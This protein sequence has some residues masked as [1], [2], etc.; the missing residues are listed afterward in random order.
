[1]TNLSRN[2]TLAAALVGA[3]GVTPAVHAATDQTSA[4]PVL[5]AVVVTAQKR[6][7]NL[8]DVPISV[9]AIDSAALTQRNVIGL[10]DINDGLVPGLNLAPYPGSADF[11]LPTFR[12]IS[13]NT[14]FISTPNPFAIHVDGVFISQFVGLNN[15]AADIERIEVLKGPQ[16]VLS[17]RNST[18]GAI[19]IYMRK[20]ELG[21]FG[22]KQEL[23]FA[24]R[25]QFVSKTVFN[26]PMGETFAAKLAYAYTKRGNEGIYN[27]AP[28]GIQFGERNADDL[29]VD[30]RWKP[31]DSALTAD[32]SFDRSK[33]RGYDTPSQCLYPAPAI[34]ALQAT[35]DP[36]IATF[37]AGCT[38]AKLA[39]VYMPFDIPKNN[40]VVEAHTLN[41][42]WQVASALTIRSITGYRTVDTLNSYNY[43]AY[44][45][46]ADVRS[47]SYPLLVPGTPF[48]GQSHP[49]ALVDR[50][51]SEELQ[52][53][54]DAGK[55]ISYTAG[56]YYSTEN[57]HQDSGPNVGIY[58]PSAVPYPPAY[59]DFVAV[60][61]KGLHSSKSDSVAVYGQLTWRPDAFDNKLEIVPGV[62]YTRDHR[63]A[64]GYNLGWTTGYGVI[65]TGPG[66]GILAFPF[67]IAAPDV[68][69]ASAKGDLTF[70]KTTPSLSF[71][72]HWTDA[73]MLYAKYVE[74]YTSGGFDP[75]SGPATAAQ[76][77]RGFQPQTIKSYE[78]GLKGEFLDR[79]LRTNL[80]IFE[81]KFKN[82]QK[83]VALP[84]G[85]WQT[86]N[87]A[88]STYKGAEFDL[89]AAITTGLTLTVS[90]ATLDHKYSKWIDPNSGADVTS[91]RRLIVPKNDYAATLNYR[92]PD[93]GLPGALKGMVSYT[94][95][96][97]TS[98]PLNLTIPNVETYSTTPAFSLLDARLDLTEINIGTGQLSVG[99]WGKN[100][101][102]KNYL[103]LAYQGWVT[104]SSGSWGDPR[105]YGV[106]LK[107]EF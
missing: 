90:Y 107:Y 105:T 39:A 27:S 16:G 77:S 49:V 93:F 75:V 20:P 69:F 12:G 65:Q 96:D 48:D 7:E 25:G 67:P 80:T 35:G 19:N 106:D 13:S 74:G 37:I 47:D 31:A 58:Q 15:P 30:L 24:K 36:R 73:V 59:F 78:A 89:T 44:A 10:S 2:F 55:A 32:Y 61:Q 17:G 40:N 68:G 66:Q 29:R 94:H 76:F 63:V 91:L 84:T 26:V 86:Q 23:T 98:T 11:Y 60:D 100:L 79:R 71:N 103:T 70:S 42:A 87:V 21:K 92:F 18:G 14:A 97:R 53:L 52:F 28:G 45:G 4:E 85:G 22:F 56:L 88:G 102:D 41:L 83:S 64:D 34:T 3:L 50:A 54:G 43:G 82:E 46:G 38:P 51:F 72:Y 6:E 5:E 104:A 1:M 99:V 8:Q 101:T 57:G 9:M 81:S 95:R 33:S 62:R